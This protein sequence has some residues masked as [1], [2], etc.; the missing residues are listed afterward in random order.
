MIVPTQL[1]IAR[2]AATPAV[3]RAFQ[4]L[5]LHQPQLRR[6]HLDIVRIPAPPFAEEARAAW[7]LERFQELGLTNPHIDVVGN[8]LAELPGSNH[9]ANDSPVILLS[10]HLD[11]VFPAQTSTEP[12]EQ[13]TRILAPGA[14][15]NAAG[16]SA[17]LGL[18]AALR[19]AELG[20]AVTILFAANVGEEGEGD[21]RGMRHLF[22]ASPYASRIAGALALEGSGSSAV[23][24]RALASRRFRVT[25]TGPGGHAWTDA[26]APNPILMLARALLALEALP[27]L[28]A[29]AGSP[30]TT[31]NIGQIAGGTSIN[32]IPESAVASIDLRST[33]AAELQ[34]A[35]EALRSTLKHWILDPPIS[36]V[37]LSHGSVS[38]PS[39]ALSIEIIG[40][41]PGGSLA[42][43][44]QL[45]TT[46]RAVDRHLNLR[47]EPGLGSTDA[48]IPLSLGIPAIAIGAGGLGGGI[49]TLQEWYD[50]TGRNNALR[51][52]LLTLLDTA[53]LA[54][55][56]SSSAP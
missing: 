52:I 21:L 38:N 43:D 7:F 31:L 20:A 22:T 49:H 12:I 9:T 4:W 17:L 3:H 46:L 55:P 27:S 8:V 44:S 19:H 47:T 2:L 25:V 54:V 36:N 29:P 45:L 37:H 30:R 6:W 50:P 32:S 41:R 5:H 13:D 11:T 42:D 23:V 26:G 1:R 48:N 53:Q 14:C 33:D 39:V 56:Q 24:T 35:E 10:A 15:D 28:A 51:R 16:L 18:A 34:A 40:D